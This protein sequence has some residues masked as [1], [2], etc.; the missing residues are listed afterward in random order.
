MIFSI[1]RYPN[2]SYSAQSTKRAL[3]PDGR[4]NFFKDHFDNSWSATTRIQPFIRVVVT[5]LQC[6]AM[7]L[8]EGFGNIIQQ[9]FQTNVT[10][11]REIFFHPC[12]ASRRRYGIRRVN[13][14]WESST[15]A[16]TVL[17]FTETE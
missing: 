1:L 12:T 5:Q 6:N 17:L 3:G 15:F 8:M 16:G 4:L 13:P 11:L 9:R 2:V 10:G 7:S 14:V